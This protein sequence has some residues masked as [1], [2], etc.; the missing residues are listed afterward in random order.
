[1]FFVVKQIYEQ[2]AKQKGVWDGYVSDHLLTRVFGFELLMAPYA[3]AHLKLGMELQDTGY[4]F[5]SDERLGIYLT[6]TLEEAALKSEKLFAQWIS[7]EANAAAEI[8]R[9][10]PILVVLGNPPYSGVSANRSKDEKGNL[11]FIGG[12]IEDYKE[13]DGKHLKER[14]HWL[15]DDYV[16]FIRFA[17]W[18]IDRTGHGILGFITNH[19]YLDNPTFRGMRQHLMKSFSE[20]YV[21]NL[22]GNSKKKEQAPDGTKDENVFDIQQGVAILLAIKQPEHKGSVKVHHCNLWGTR[23]KK[24][25]ALGT[26]SVSTTAWDTITPSS[27]LY[28]FIPENK[29]D[30]AEY[31][32][33][34]SLSDAMPVKNTGVITAR[35][36]FITDFTDDPIE[37]RVAVFLDSGL[38]DEEVKRQ[39]DL[40]ENYAWR[41]ADARKQLRK[42]KNPNSLLT[43][44]LYRPFDK[45]RILYDKSVVWRTRDAVMRHMLGGKNVGLVTTRL[46]KDKWGC[47]VTDAVMGHKA[48]AAYD[49]NYLFPAVILDSKSSLNENHE[50][51]AG[52][53]PNFSPAFLEELSKR[54]G[55]S[56]D[57][58]SHMPVG[59]SVEDIIGYAYAIFHSAGYQNRY[60]EFLKRDFPRLPLTSDHRLFEA[61][62]QKGGELISLHL[63]KSACLEKFVTAFPV[64]GDNVIAK[65]TYTAEKQRVSI[66]AE[67]YFEGV[68][69]HIW[70]AFVGGYQVCEK[71]L[72]DRKGRKLS[73]DEVQHWQRM[74]VAIEETMRLT[75]EIDGLI[76]AWPLR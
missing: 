5:T 72:K 6:N 46:T 2:F 25:I 54:L 8:K 39:L 11:T 60:S 23:E 21:Y 36:H 55:V 61:L 26:E 32:S 45:R 73:Y 29:Q 34:W 48:L 68:Q 30:Q 31:Q 47:F 57:E 66:N 71:W 3:V 35:D 9:D 75:K 20:L 76:P 59:V 69:Q 14:K 62:S 44:F 49:I 28:L 50:L 74:V 67:Q 16:K 56:Q 42:V 41:V 22:H 7:D 63:L 37:K 1:L 53:R 19:G 52:K 64:K 65:V 18:R 24:Y 15:Q 51:F 17:Q 13:V 33:F 10:R 12:L 4:T 58:V 40:N 70:E 38:S 43:D 27:P